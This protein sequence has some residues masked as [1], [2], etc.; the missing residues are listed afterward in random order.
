MAYWPAPGYPGMP[1]GYPPYPMHPRGMPLPGAHPYPPATLP[2]KGPPAGYYMAPTPSPVLVTSQSSAGTS[3]NTPS[4]GSDSESSQEKASGVPMPVKSSL[5]TPGS[6]LKPAA[7][8]IEKRVSFA[9]EVVKAP[10]VPEVPKAP[11]DDGYNPTVTGMFIIFISQAFT[12]C[13]QSAAKR[14]KPGMSVLL[15]GI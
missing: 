3:R 8:G 14:R 10:P 1:Y 12:D 2:V 11:V 9:D 7:P 6:G 5:V 15:I 13:P 4:Q